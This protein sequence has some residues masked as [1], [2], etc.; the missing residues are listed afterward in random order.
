MSLPFVLGETENYHASKWHLQILMWQYKVPGCHLGRW[1][2]IFLVKLGHSPTDIAIYYWQLEAKYKLPP[3][4]HHHHLWQSQFTPKIYVKSYN[5]FLVIDWLLKWMIGTT[6]FEICL[7]MR[8]IL[9]H[10]WGLSEP[11]GHGVF[12][13]WEIPG[14][15][16]ISAA[17]WC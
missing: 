6:C 17:F 12:F 14:F 9:S 1:R 11:G 7:F 15:N 13:S 5:R 2:N 8:Y 3:Q 16:E 4:H 10:L